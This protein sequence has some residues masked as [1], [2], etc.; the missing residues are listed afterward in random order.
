MGIQTV[1]LSPELT[2]PQARDIGGD[3]ALTVYG[4]IPLM[5]L[6]KCVI[7]EIAD[8]KRCQ[9]NNVCLRDRKGI[10]FPVLR[11]WEHRNVIYNSLPT[12]MSDKQEALDRAH[13]RV[14]HFIFTIESPEE[15]DKVIGAYL[16]HDSLPFPVRRLS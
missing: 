11:E 8:C 1:L 5:T 6:E 4:R 14:R 13:I 2:L 16:E 9:E 10:E 12:N 15:V 7:K 3:T